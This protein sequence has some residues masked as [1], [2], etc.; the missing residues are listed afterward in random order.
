M[1]K[2][3]SYN[4]P[5]GVAGPT[6]SDRATAKDFGGDGGMIAG[7]KALRDFGV[8]LENNRIKKENAAVNQ[9]NIDN[10][11]YG[12]DLFRSA[13]ENTDANATDFTSTVLAEYDKNMQARLDAAPNARVRQQMEAD[14]TRT[15]NGLVEKSVVYESAVRSKNEV[16]VFVGNGDKAGNI[17]F[18]TPTDDQYNITKDA[19]QR[20][21]DNT[22]LPQHIKDE[23]MRDEVKILRFR[24]YEG[25]LEGATSKEQVDEILDARP[26]KEMSKEGFTQL[27]NAGDAKKRRFLTE[28]RITKVEH[29]QDIRD[30]QSAVRVANAQLAQGR[31]PDEATLAHTESLV[32]KVGDPVTSEMWFNVKTVG[33]A[34]NGWKKLPSE[35]LEAIIIG[36][37]EDTVEGGATALEGSKLDAARAVLTKVEAGERKEQVKIDTDIREAYDSFD[38]RLEGGVD[39]SED[40]GFIAMMAQLPGASPRLQQQIKEAVALNDTVSGLIDSPIADLRKLVEDAYANRNL[41]DLKIVELAAA[42]KVLADMVRITDKNYVDYQQKVD[43][44]DFPPLDESNP[45][46]MKTRQTLME[47]GSQKYKKDKQFHTTAEIKN[48]GDRMVDMSSDEQLQFINGYTAN[49]SKENAAIALTELAA[50]NPQLA[51]VGSGIAHDPAYLVTG[52]TI[53]RGQQMLTNEGAK[54]IEAVTLGV[55]KGAT[56]LTIQTSLI[57]ALENENLHPQH[58]AAVM[59]SALAIVASGVEVDAAKALNMALGGDNDGFGG[60]QIIN[61]ANFAAPVG[62]S[63]DMITDAFDTDDHPTALA[64]LSVDGS[65]PRTINGVVITGDAIADAGMMEQVGPDMYVVRMKS[66]GK[67]LQGKPGTPYTMHLTRERLTTLGVPVSD[68]QDVSPLSGPGGG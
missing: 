61:G 45:Q 46:S 2:F 7:G 32:G 15:R 49:M 41:S 55:T 63:A 21:V 48:I 6:N 43:P 50:V 52:T 31:I 39:M 22:S 36:L 17:L 58:R 27:G 18:E 53:L 65:T 28:A 5:Q 9:S 26:G 62:V 47:Q 29:K 57:G 38:K 8:V 12:A 64:E 11:G 42:Q 1:A 54:R 16:N 59:S 51:F 24:Q 4:A 25:L 33:E 66:D 40:A 67:L 34:I 35:D 13:K 68:G 14:F 19:R 23:L 37:E 44:A 3:T 10:Q 30:A 60:V 20:E 56:E